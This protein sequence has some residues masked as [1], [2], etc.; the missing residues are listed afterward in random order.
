MFGDNALFKLNVSPL[1]ECREIAFPPI[2]KVS[3]SFISI[4]LL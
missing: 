2:N 4:A 1:D 3:A